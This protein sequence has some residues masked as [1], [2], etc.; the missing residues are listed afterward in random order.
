MI[1]FYLSEVDSN[2]VNAILALVHAMAWYLTD[3][4]KPIMSHFADAY[5]R[6]YYQMR[7]CV[8]TWTTQANAVVP[9]GETMCI[10]FT[11]AWQ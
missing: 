11:G 2:M 3:D 7:N 5:M 4:I 8:D 10:E 9:L 1:G 6:H